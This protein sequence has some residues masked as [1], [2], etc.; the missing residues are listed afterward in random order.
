MR[1]GFIFALAGVLVVGAGLAVWLFGAGGAQPTTD[2]TAPPVTGTTAE[3]PTS[4]APSV[5]PSSG[6]LTFELSD[7]TFA[8]FEIDEVLR[9]S[10]NRVVAVSDVVVGEILFDPSTLQDSTIGTVLVNAR[11]FST[12][13]SLRDRAIRGR[14]LESDSFEFI[15]FSPA[16]ITGLPETAEEGDRIELS[17]SGELRIRGITRPVEFLVRAVFESPE[18]ITGVA[19]AVV[20]RSDFELSIPNVASVAGVSDEV[21]IGIEFEAVP[22]G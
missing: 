22:A 3:S 5:S 1:R 7:A 15:E 6:S 20:L 18:R 4:V 9:G 8:Y 19:E 10:P 11:A 2:V 16:S 17:V 13:S 12:D 14:I 21:L